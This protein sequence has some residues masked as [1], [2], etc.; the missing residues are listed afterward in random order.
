MVLDALEPSHSEKL[1]CS[2]ISSQTTVLLCLSAKSSCPFSEIVF[3]QFFTGLKTHKFEA[4]QSHT[5]AVISLGETIQL[6]NSFSSEEASM[7]F[8]SHLG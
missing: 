4:T 8:M 6:S 5:R 1:L 2:Y 7:Q 3:L